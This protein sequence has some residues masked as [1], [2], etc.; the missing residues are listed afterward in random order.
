MSNEVVK[1]LVPKSKKE[2]MGKYKKGNTNITDHRNSQ[3]PS[4]LMYT[5]FLS[6]HS[7]GPKNLS[8]SFVPGV[9]GEE[10]LTMVVVG[11]A[12]GLVS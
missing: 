10:L 6:Q 12:V 2:W 9:V 7:C 8:V 3:K 11:W 5:Y 1:L 4:Q